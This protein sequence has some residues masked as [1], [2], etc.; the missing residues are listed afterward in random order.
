MK[1]VLSFLK[2]YNKVFKRVFAFGALILASISLVAIFTSGSTHQTYA[3]FPGEG[4]QQA[5]EQQPEDQRQG[6]VPAAVGG[7]E[8]PAANAGSLADRISKKFFG[9]AKFKEW[10]KK[11]DAGYLREISG[12]IAKAVGYMSNAI[13]DLIK[14]AK[15]GNV[16]VMP[17]IIATFKSTMNLMTTFS[18]FFPGGSGVVD[19]LIDG[20]ITIVE[21]FDGSKQSDTARLM[22][23][24][25]DQIILVRE[26][27]VKTRQ[28][29]VELSNEF[30]EGFNEIL[31]A[32]KDAFEN[33]EAKTRVNDFFSTSSGNF[34]Y[35]Q[36][37]RY[38][39]SD[40]IEGYAHELS[41][42]VVKE[43]PNEEL[44]TSLSNKLYSALMSTS[45]ERTSYLE[46]FYDNIVQTDSH[47]SIFEYYADF[48]NSNSKYLNGESPAAA[49]VEFMSDVYS[50]F[51]TS[52]NYVRTL[53]AQ[54]QM[55][56]LL[57]VEDMNNVDFDTL[58]YTYGT[59]ENDYVTYSDL[60]KIDKRLN[61]MLSNVDYQV[62]KDI[63]YVLKLDKNYFYQVSDDAYYTDKEKVLRTS[64]KIKEET[65]GN[66][67]R[68]YKLKFSEINPIVAE[69]FGYDINNF[70]YYIT[71]SDGARLNEGSETTPTFVVN[72]DKPFTLVVKYEV[73]DKYGNPVLA[74]N[75]Q[76]EDVPLIY[77][78]YT[79]SF[80][81]GVN[82]SFIA[83][84]GTQQDPYIIGN[85]NQLKLISKMD[86][87]NS[88]SLI[89][90]IDLENETISQ[91]FDDVTPYAGTFNGNG[92]TISH[93]K[94]ATSKKQPSLFGYIS[95]TGSVEN[96]RIYNAEIIKDNDNDSAKLIA[97]ILAGVNN[98][99]ISRV[100]IDSC[101]VKVSRES[102]AKNNNVNK[103]I[104]VY[105]GGI[106]A[107]N[108]GSIKYCNVSGTKV[109]GYS[110]RHYGSN[111][112][113]SNSNDVYAGGA[114]GYNGAGAEL[115]YIRI[116]TNVSVNSEAISESR[117]SFST[118]DH[119][120]KSYAGGV[121][122]YASDKRNIN[123]LYC[124]QNVASAS[125][126]NKNY[127]FLAFESDENVK[128]ATSIYVV[129]V[130]NTGIY[131]LS[132]IG[133]PTG[134]SYTATLKFSG[135]LDPVFNIDKSLLINPN[136]KAF[137]PDNMEL[138]VKNNSTQKTIIYKPTIIAVRGFD[139]TNNSMTEVKERELEVDVV[140]SGVN[141]VY[142]FK[143]KYVVLPDTPT[144]ISVK[145]AATTEFAYS[146]DESAK[147]VD[148][149]ANQVLGTDS[150]YIVTKTGKEIQINDE[151][152]ISIDVTK[153][154]KQKVSITA[155]GFT[156][157]SFEVNVICASHSWI[158][159]KRIV[160]G[161]EAFIDPTT[162]ET[163]FR[164]HGYST[165]ECEH[166]HLIVK[167]MFTNIY[168]TEIINRVE[169]TCASAGYTGDRVPYYLNDNQEKIYLD[170]IIEKGKAIQT[171]PHTYQHEDNMNGRTHPEY[172][173]VCDMCGHIEP[174]LYSLV[175]NAGEVLNGLVYVC[176]TCGHT[177]I[178]EN[179]S[180]E[181]ITKLPRVVVNDTYALVGN[182][183]VV[184][185]VDLH[186]NVGITSAN[187]SIIYDSNLTLIS[188][189]L[190][191][192]LND[193]RI[194]SFKAYGDHL[195]VVLAQTSTDVSTDGTILKLVFETPST[196][197]ALDRFKIDVVNK[198]N[199]DRF[200][201][202]AGN[203]LEFLSYEG[204]VNV[205]D[206]L[207]GDVNSDG[208][209]D[210]LDS[211]IASKYIVLDESEKASYI[212][213]MESL[214]PAFDIS[215]AD[216]NLDNVIDTDDVVRLLRF[217]VG[218]YESQIVSQK[219]IVNLN[220]NDGTGTVVPYLVDYN[221]GK[222][223]Y[224]NLP[225]PQ[226]TGYR[227]DGWFTDIDGGDQV[228]ATSNVKYNNEQ[229]VQT[230][231][232]HFT[233]NKITFD[234]NGG[235]GEKPA[236]T[237]YTDSKD[238]NFSI[239]SPTSEPYIIKES[240][241][242]FDANLD[243]KL[244][245]KT[246]SYR[247][248]FLGWSTSPTGNVITNLNSIY[249]LSSFKDSQVGSVTLYAIW[250]DVVIDNYTP[251]DSSL[252]GYT[253]SGWMTKKNGSFS[254]VIWSSNVSTYNVTESVAFYAKWDLVRYQIIYDGTG[255][256]T[257]QG[258][259]LYFEENQRNSK[260]A[261][262]L[263]AISNIG[264]TKTGYTFSGWATDPAFAD[265]W[266]YLVEKNY[267]EIVSGFNYI[268]YDGASRA[269][270]NDDYV[271]IDQALLQATANPNPA[272]ARN[273]AKF[274]TSCLVEDLER[275]I[276]ENGYVTL[277]ALWTPNKIDITYRTDSLTAKLAGTG[278][279]AKDNPVTL[280][281]YYGY[282]IILP[283]DLYKEPFTIQGAGGAVHNFNHSISKFTIDLL[284]VTET[285]STGG[286]IYAYNLPTTNINA[287]A[288]VEFET[289]ERET[290]YIH[291][292]YNG[293][294]LFNEA[295]YT[296]Y[297]ENEEGYTFAKDLS[298]MGMSK[299]YYFINSY[300]SIVDANGKT[301]YD[302]NN[303]GTISEDE[304]YASLINVGTK[305]TRNNY[306]DLYISVELVGGK[307]LIEGNNSPFGRASSYTFVIKE[308][309]DFTPVR[310]DKNIFIVPDKIVNSLNELES[311]N[312]L[313]SVTDNLTGNYYDNDH[314]ENNFK[315]MILPFGLKDMHP[316][317]INP[318]LDNIETLI[319]P[320]VAGVLTGINITSKTGSL[321][322][323]VLSRIDDYN[324]SSLIYE[325]DPGCMVDIYYR[326][327]ST[328]LALFESRYP[329][330]PIFD[331]TRFKVRCYS[332][333]DD[334]SN[335]Y[336][337]YLHGVIFPV[338]K[339]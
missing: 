139:S 314:P 26:D 183:Q 216:V 133:W 18:K 41:Y 39:F 221:F 255:G 206:H 102:E 277:Y 74:K 157:N 95:S 322:R 152:T 137:Y 108:Y 181:E 288:V 68:G 97:G 38:L 280:S 36:L 150:I 332:E 125:A 227:F 315:V 46:M 10:R 334:D 80:R 154:G 316:K 182:H 337:H 2:K 245:N 178:R 24:I 238:L 127:G 192:I 16:Q 86:R 326:G 223:T 100:I 291:Y 162:Q 111:A 72:T 284:G 265:T 136:T 266:F 78:I 200:T 253:L 304:E 270:T 295:M 17:M 91:F 110:K 141:T 115:S 276:D 71:D 6:E 77:T 165:K 167:E 104:Q 124:Y 205:V 87:H 121:A 156:D 208:A 4:G 297:E 230:L 123:M 69:L 318:Y 269:I 226:K 58:K 103:A 258:N 333:I 51:L 225:T 130:D 138:K 9:N 57:E 131:S 202:N 164:L 28:D 331:K 180:K 114:V 256:K 161:Y 76:G 204:Y 268:Y 302:I 151:A 149:K 59:G 105:V 271:F 338:V 274:I 145:K 126:S 233:I 327:T 7:Q 163:Y 185:Y 215:Y 286:Y 275:F 187:F 35:T 309:G 73:K 310:N 329:Q 292:L 129:G 257:A 3:Y 29:I 317:A 155:K 306:P 128:K 321:K 282:D 70:R 336:W 49:S 147:I 220:Y 65:F 262:T 217:D 62:A 300:K 273:S 248:V 175:E 261:R 15:S 249:N 44:I 13:A 229:Y 84:S 312:E 12:S 199:S 160:E 239:T 298:A 112:D 66:V 96:L 186:A 158:N 263:E 170:Y 243:N 43:N 20:F 222:G 242:T 63:A 189:Q 290:R 319:L 232:A 285:K 47:R 254:D 52:I 241:V 60:E 67:E 264:F 231:Y 324:N 21:A 320:E 53:G 85:V 335:I 33:F 195:N 209:I 144:R 142:T 247:H 237:L 101:N 27:I 174:H 251:T 168:A 260:S 177:I 81:V 330:A 272:M 118:R 169:A 307:K 325:T 54:Q 289:E 143:I 193:T 252:D 219:F 172:G 305:L 211:L 11:Q 301:G 5:P 25:S 299:D 218:G 8:N 92:H 293:Y 61:E 246:D 1:K 184:V 207:P 281:Y 30:D 188:Y 98:G 196:A 134:P 323:I 31:T 116:N 109:N 32:L 278:I 135:E 55:A 120:I 171:I 328:D 117:K 99:S 23:F 148:Q 88:Y 56:M 132:D 94:L 294:E 296:Y 75:D 50:T 235:I 140:A 201:D 64:Y 89:T 106:V 203:K 107:E 48:L 194:S 236:I 283:F 308:N 234:P 90:D 287:E 179:V 313:V 259:S 14:S 224:G 42:Q 122:G 303:N 146:T 83:G 311:V 176:E 190:G 82:D 19:A 339:A 267:N 197:V 214:N 212:K 198:G 40:A 210:M 191:N 159:E 153:L 93:F 244:L 22:S 79:M 166:C 45:R 34:S 119:Y 250:K 37:K 279:S 213:E 173:H 240:T 228:L 113:G